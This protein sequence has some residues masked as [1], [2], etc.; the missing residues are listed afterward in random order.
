MSVDKLILAI[1]AL[2][3]FGALINGTIGKKLPKMIV[4][5]IATTVMFVS[6][7]L[8]LIVFN[9]NHHQT[10]INLFSV[11]KLPVFAPV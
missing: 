10:I 8:A 6:F 9:S 7:A 1:L 11:I 2:P 4:G 5:S 3:L